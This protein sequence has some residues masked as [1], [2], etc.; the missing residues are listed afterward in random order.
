[1]TSGW[2]HVQ[3]LK[4]PAG[5]VSNMEVQENGDLECCKAIIADMQT[6]VW[7]ITWPLAM[8]FNY[9]VLQYI[10]QKDPYI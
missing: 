8:K 2:T 5:S 3:S 7:A 1:M 9:V 4:L 6:L 10:T